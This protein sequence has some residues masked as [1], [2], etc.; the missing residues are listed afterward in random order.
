MVATTFI[1]GFFLT[2]G[3]SGLALLW[4]FLRLPLPPAIGDAVY[5][6]T[7][8]LGFGVALWVMERP[9]VCPECGCI[10]SGFS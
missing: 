1:Y 5:L 7:F 2:L 6:V 4:S 9:R 10:S 3:G 8:G